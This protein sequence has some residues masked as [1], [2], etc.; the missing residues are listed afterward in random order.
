[1]TQHENYTL[2][3]PFT[4]ILTM[5]NLPESGPITDDE[6]EVLEDGGIVICDG[7]IRLVGKYNILLKVAQEE[8]Y[9]IE[10]ITEPKVLLPGLIDAHTHICFAGSRAN[11]YAMRV[12]GK[13]YL[14]IARNGGGILDS[15][16]KTR[17]ATVIE[18]VDL[19]KKRCDRHLSEG[20]TTCEVK[21]GYGLTV[22]E[23]LKMLEAIKLVNTHHKID[24]VPTCLAA[25]MRPPEY[26][27]S[28]LYLQHVLENLLPQIKEQ[29]LANRVDI[30]IEDTAFN[31]AD[32]LEYLM[33]AKEMGFDI[34]VHADQFSTDGSSVAAEAG[35]ISADHLEAS[36]EE[37]IALLKEAGVVATVLPGASVGLG[38]HYAPARKMLDGGLCVAIATDWN[39][40]SAP[41][42]DLLMQAALIGAS[43]KL[44]IAETLAAVTTRAAKA[45]NIKDRGCLGKEQ[46][47]DM[48]AFDTGNYKE[49]LYFQGKLKPTIVWKRGER[50]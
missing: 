8:H 45:L 29:G 40:G 6:L 12:A 23:E 44:T 38:M 17:E 2:I 37:E 33:A 7:K 42:G 25:H 34:T 30:F 36:G 46:V 31:E 48:I 15:V 41:M 43:E 35:A 20:V 4:Q 9:K 22:E 49:I 19:L 21:S 13:T 16:R 28:K 24:L 10:K 27:D 14:E 32:S 5:A 18:L 39:P 3:G 47:A 50:V 11:D 26:S 1:M